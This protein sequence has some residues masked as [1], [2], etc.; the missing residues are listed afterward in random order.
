MTGVISTT[1]FA[2][3]DVVLLAP[4]DSASCTITAFLSGQAGDAHVDNATVAA[5]GEEGSRATADDAAVVLFTDVIPEITV[6][7][8]ADQPSVDETGEFVTFTVT[9]END[10]LEPLTVDSLSDDVYGDLT[11]VADSTCAAGAVLEPNDGV[12]GSGDDTYICAFTV[13]VAQ[14]GTELQHQDSVVVTVHDNDGNSR[15]ASDDEIVTFDLI[16][17]TVDLTKQD[18]PD[19]NATS[20]NPAVTS[21]TR[22]P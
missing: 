20:T 14:L 22:S 13:F 5:I 8:T 21:R 3:E 17:P 6:T 12:V 19:G 11:K 7:K 4:G 16:P 10:T 15:S 18:L 1:C 2:L 9:A